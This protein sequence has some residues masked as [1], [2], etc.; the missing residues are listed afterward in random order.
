MEQ[1]Y[2]VVIIGES[3]VGKTTWLERYMTGYFRKNYIATMGCEVHPIICRTNQG[4]TTLN[5]WDCAGQEKYKGLDEGYYIGAKLVIIM[6]DLGSRVTL[7][8]VKTY[9]N[10]V[11]NVTQNIP[12]VL[13]GNKIDCKELQVT[14]EMVEKLYP[15][16]P[17]LYTSAKL[18]L[19]FDKLIL[20]VLNRLNQLNEMNRFEQVDFVK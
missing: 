20:D 5:V 9:I 1:T 17:C 10:K 12:I 2:K 3:G 4:T 13:W 18:Q 16:F 7:N 14:K 6:F 15:D 11:Q 19:D 8:N